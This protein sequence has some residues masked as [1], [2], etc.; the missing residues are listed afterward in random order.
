LGKLLGGV[1]PG[2]PMWQYNTGQMIGRMVGPY[3]IDA[4][5]GSGGMGVVY[6]GTD[7][8]LD[9]PVAL[10][11]LP[12]AAAHE[13][14]S[15]ERFHR[16][17]RLVASLS[18]PGICT[19]HDIGEHDGQSY[20]VM[21]LLDGATLQ[22]RMGGRS[23]PIDEVIAVGIELADALAA[24]HQRG[25]VHRDLKPANIV[26]TSQGRAKILDFGVATLTTEHAAASLHT[27]TRLT[28]V[29]QAVGT[30]AYMAPEQ[31]RGELADQRADLFAIGLV[32]YEMASGKAA[33][34]GLTS[35]VMIDA[36]LNRPPAP[37]RS[38]NPAVPPRLEDIIV[39][40]LEKDPGMR[41]QHAADLRADL[42]RLQRD[43]GMAVG[44]APPIPH[45]AAQRAGPP[46]IAILPFADLS[47]AKDQQYFCEGMADEIMTALSSMG[48]IQV[49][50]RTSAVRCRE[51]GMDL[52]EIWQRLNVETVLDG[53]V[54]KAGNRLRISAHLTKVQ[55]GYQL[56]AE[57]YDRDLDDIFAVQ[58]EIARAIAD[59]LRV[60]LTGGQEQAVDRGTD[61]LE[62]YNLYLQGR[63]HWARRN[64]WQLGIALES[65]TKAVEL[66]SNYAHAYA[67]LA[68][69]YTALAV[70][71]VQPAAKFR[72]AGTAAAERACSL[73]PALAETN[74]SRG[75]VRAFLHWDLKG[76]EEALR[77]AV[78][79]NPRLTISHGYLGVLL[80]SLGRVPEAVEFM[81]RALSL[82]PDSALI[83]YMGSSIFLWS[84]D[85]QR[86]LALARRSLDLE[87]DAPYAH[88]V[89]SL[90]LSFLG[91]TE[92]AVRSAE[93][94]VERGERLPMLMVSLGQVYAGA[95]RA[96]D[97]EAV[98]A[99][100][101]ERSA[102]EYI[103]PI[104]S[105]D[106]AAALGRREDACRWLER[107]IA[108]G[109]G[110]L[111]RVRMSPEYDL[112]RD[113]P[114]FKVVMDRLGL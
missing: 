37:L 68:D 55:D 50:S 45:P 111:I 104:Y 32:L 114:R 6:R 96:A 112:V 19:L 7:T 83:A 12:A 82:E 48:N 9:R 58:D 10:K 16:E 40:L 103:A 99:E 11:F 41:Y 70:Y 46:S 52:A 95:G 53:S 44:V 47:P 101:G 90:S 74:H 64:R 18:H 17:A 51:K 59:R 76:A 84:R 56:W 8:R 42:R 27:A 73:A 57:R 34:G 23:R 69:C 25:I 80:A 72:E 105:L 100:L 65:F 13:R 108:E 106:I 33:F 67:G 71:S 35:G 30:L 78:V 26:I 3:R 21:E 61:N 2:A 49:A 77:A 88:W 38:I 97:A 24:A 29:G 91:R 43:T 36:M 5:L 93:Q 87:P 75:G 15:L 66:D 54:R 89:H 109:N 63:Y 107:A 94:A 22:E 98:L 20:L 39:K 62:A 28:G 86:S 79:L 113:D 60:K 110:L 102:R 92:E 31:L 1:K 4:P 14:Q 81:E 85:Y